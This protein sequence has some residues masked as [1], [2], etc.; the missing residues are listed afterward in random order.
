MS[1]I[2]YFEYDEIKQEVFA[3]E[4][5]IIFKQE[6]VVPLNCGHLYYKGEKVGDYQYVENRK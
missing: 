3:D 5:P 1:V 2:M 4:I 6:I